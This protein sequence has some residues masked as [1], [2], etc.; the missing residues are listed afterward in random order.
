MLMRHPA[1][2]APAADT[3]AAG[4]ARRLDA[5][6]LDRDLGEEAPYKVGCLSMG[7]GLMYGAGLRWP[8]PNS[9]DS[10]PV[11]MRQDDA[12][13]PTARRRLGGAYLV[14]TGI[15]VLPTGRAATM[16]VWF[17]IIADRDFALVAALVPAIIVAWT[18]LGVSA[19]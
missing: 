5:V 18:L 13:A 17:L 10:I 3:P 12:Q 11:V 1:S 8:K 9:C 15:V 14:S 2:A 7:L 19:P 4:W 6:Y 16:A